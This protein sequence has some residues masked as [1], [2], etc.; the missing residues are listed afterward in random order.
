MP[1]RS[2]SVSRR[3]LLKSSGALGI[4]GIAGIGF[5]AILRAQPAPIRIG[6]QHPVTGFLAYSGN[7]CRAGAL[8]AIEAI[9]AAGGIKSLGGARLEAVLSDNQSKVDV[10]LSEFEKLA[11]SGISA[12]VGP[13]ASA[14]GIATSQAAARYNLPHVCDVT[15]SDLVISRNKPSV[16]R[17]SP[18]YGQIAVEAIERLV[19]INDD[20]GKPVRSVMLVHEESESGAGA[21]KQLLA[22]LPRHGFEI[23][24][25]ILHPNP[26]RDFTNIVL[27][28]RQR[29]PD[30]LIVGN[31]YNEYVLLVRTLHQQKIGLKGI[32][33]VLGGG[34][35]SFRFLRESPAAAQYTMDCN[36][37]FN[38]KSQKAL[39]LQRRVQA[40]G[41][42]F[43][44]E[45][46]LN[47]NAIEL[48]ADSLERAASSKRDAIVAA[49]AS[50]TFSGHMLPY[51]RTKFV[52][53][54]NA[55]ARSSTL[56]V[57][58]NRIELILPAEFSS[59]K[60]VFPRPL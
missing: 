34:A 20:A 9:N 12:F 21:Q 42:D 4:A 54:Q 44:F 56:Q 43:S 51:G 60:P 19:R 33:S 13:Y 15:I 46:W 50:S 31:F 23:V 27:R 40:A 22:Q 16:F 39:A 38:P 59:A 55:G 32:Y 25:S 18:G 26:T 8:M 41:R 45:L 10:G 52:N 7:Q 47:Y 14:I 36:H 37:W 2:P 5:P 30:L 57:Q 24:D 6:I 48:L 3:S 35:S 28:I 17:F 58:G 49:L 11:E 29:R 1:A 53:G